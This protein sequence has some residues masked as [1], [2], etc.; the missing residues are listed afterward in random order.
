MQDEGGHDGEVEFPDEWNTDALVQ[1]IRNADNGATVE[2]QL[3]QTTTLSQ[4]V[5]ESLQG[6]NVTLDVTLPDGTVWSICGNDV[7]E[8]EA[9][10]DLAVSRKSL[11][12]GNISADRITSLIQGRTT[13]QLSFGQNGSYGFIGSLTL[14]AISDVEGNKCVLVQ[15]CAGTLTY[16]S[17]TLI[18]NGIMELKVAQG[19]D[20]FLTYGT[21]GD[22]SGD[23]KVELKDLM[24][25]L[26]HV[27]DR[28]K[29]N[30]VEQGFADVNMDHTVNMI[31]LMKELHYVSGRDT[32]L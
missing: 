30:E 27:S 26:H 4:K 1:Q 25:I 24:Q 32:T 13:E 6:K 10:A 17:S 21:N 23:G 11:S 20:S 14:D 12:N 22:T 16:V 2:A 28:T 18:E 29:L 15:D 31:D 8:A 19:A 7:A 3:Y 5:L 9:D